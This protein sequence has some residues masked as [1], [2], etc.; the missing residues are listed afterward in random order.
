MDYDR[1]RADVISDAEVYMVDSARHGCISVSHKK[2][3]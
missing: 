2:T 1:I 3:E